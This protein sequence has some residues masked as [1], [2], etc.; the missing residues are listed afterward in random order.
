MKAKGQAYFYLKE[1]LRRSVD[2]LEALLARVWHGLH[3]CNVVA[4]SLVLLVLVVFRGLG[5][6]EQLSQTGSGSLQ[7]VV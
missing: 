2:L 7:V 6:L 1:V 3:D 4:R 5:D